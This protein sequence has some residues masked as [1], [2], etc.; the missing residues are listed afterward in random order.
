MGMVVADLSR[1]PVCG[2]PA[3]GGAPALAGHLVEQAEQSDA[4]HVM[5][6]NRHVTSQRTAPAELA[7]LLECWAAT[8]ASGEPRLRR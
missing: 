4:G 7:V 2:T 1:C 3:S 6:L 5:W 8:G